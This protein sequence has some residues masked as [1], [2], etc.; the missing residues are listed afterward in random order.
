[1]DIIL[2]YLCVF[3]TD[4][5]MQIESSPL[6]AADIIT[7]LKKQFAYLSGN[8]LF[9]IRAKLQKEKNSPRQQ[10]REILSPSWIPLDSLVR[11]FVIN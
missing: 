6:F 11:D 9:F 2:V 3:V 7:E 10:W 4:E 1:M 8:F 5:I